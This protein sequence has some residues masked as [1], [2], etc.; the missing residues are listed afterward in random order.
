MDPEDIRVLGKGTICNFAKGTRLLKPST[1]YEH[2]R[3]VLS[4]RCIGPERART[5][6]L[7]YFITSLLPA[8]SWPCRCC[9]IGQ[10]K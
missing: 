6:T 4:P 3:P 9:F 1:E 5:Q 8:N 10:N 7:F 2:K